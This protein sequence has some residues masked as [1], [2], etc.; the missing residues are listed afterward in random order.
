[1]QRARVNLRWLY[2]PLLCCGFTGAAFAQPTD[3]QRIADLERRLELLTQRLQQV[4]TVRPAPGSAAGGDRGSVAST[5]VSAAAPAAAPLG[6]AAPAPASSLGIPL[7]AF[8]DVGYAR[9]TPDPARR[10]GGFGLGT[11]DLYMT[12]SLGE[13][14]KSIVEIAFEQDADGALM[15]DLERVQVGYTFSDALTLWGG[16][17]H[18]PFGFWNSAFHHGAQIQT[19]V[20]RPR[21]LG[22]EDQGGIV[23]VH[24]VGVLGSGAVALAGGRL[25]YDLYVANGSQMV[26]G[27]LEASGFKDDNRDKM[28]GANVRHEFGGAFGGLTLGAHALTSQVGIVDAAGL[29]VGRTRL[30]LG[31]VYAVYEREPWELFAEYYAFRNRDLMGGGGRHASWAGYMQAGYE[32]TDD[33]TVYARAEKAALDQTD[34]YFATMQS[35]RSY[36]RAS[37]GLRY[38]L[39]PTT[40]LKLE[41]ARTSESQATLESR[42][43]SLRSQVA[44]RF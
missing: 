21:F 2:A 32:I 29:A 1:M 23:P 5:S 34:P 30:N 37:A 25:K 35:G 8:V 18:T 16:R 13:R 44:V 12:P 9:D 7:H 22:F 27:V 43:T 40:A 28:V 19:S 36:R 26:D 15:I 31:G 17:F 20:L 41:V 14:I 42:T 4:E 24:S 38:D 33:W 11:L 10:R 6:L 3:A 39:N